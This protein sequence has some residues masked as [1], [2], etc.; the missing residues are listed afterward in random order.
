MVNKKFQMRMNR[1]GKWITQNVS[2]ISK[3]T[4]NEFAKKKSTKFRWK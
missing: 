3:K 1:D 2:G 4:L